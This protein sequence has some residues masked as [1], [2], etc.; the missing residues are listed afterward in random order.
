MLLPLEFGITL[1]ERVAEFKPLGINICA[2]MQD[3]V[4]TIGIKRS[5]NIDFYGAKFTAEKDPFSGEYALHGKWFD[6]TDQLCG[7]VV[8]HADSSFFAEYDVIENHPTKK[9]WFLEAITAWGRNDNI[10]VEPRLIQ[11]V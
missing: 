4:K 5:L 8:F 10:K 7:S 11:R 9:F 1:D 3:F 6:N 2:A